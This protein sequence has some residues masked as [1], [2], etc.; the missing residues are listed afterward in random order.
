MRVLNPGV[1]EF[2]GEG[3]E[4]VLSVNVSRFGEEVAVEFADAGPH[5]LFCDV[6]RQ[7]VNVR[8]VQR[9]VGDDLSAPGLGDSGTLVFETAANSSAARRAGVEI[10]AVVTGVQYSVASGGEARRTVSLV[11]V[12]E[13]GVVDPVGVDA[14]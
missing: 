13:D 2:E 9:V 12:S 3:W 6:P 11:G 8:V 7:Q 14:V 4:D 5:V 10:E 1:V